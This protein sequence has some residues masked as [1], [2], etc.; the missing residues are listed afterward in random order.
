MP[1]EDGAMKVRL[2]MTAAD[3]SRDVHLMVGSHC[4]ITVG[5]PPTRTDSWYKMLTRCSEHQN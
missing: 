1:S 2:K 5:L 3:D 4:D